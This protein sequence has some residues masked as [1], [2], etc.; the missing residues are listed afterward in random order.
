ML[1]YIAHIP[2]S[3]ALLPPISKNKAREFA[4]IRAAVNEIACDIYALGVDTIILL[5]PQSLASPGNFNINLA[6]EFLIDL[7]NYSYFKSHKPAVPD[8]E[9]A[10]AIA[11]DLGLLFPVK[12][13]NSD[14]LDTCAGVAMAQLANNKKQYQIIP[15]CPSAS[16]IA[17]LADFGGGL[18][19]VLE[20]HYQKTAV[21]GLG[22]MSRILRQDD[23]HHKARSFDS[24]IIN[25]LSSGQDYELN[26]E[27]A[28]KYQM[29]AYRPLNVIRGILRNVNYKTET[30][31]YQ[32]IYGVGMMV[33]RFL[34]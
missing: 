9:I 10:A 23:D 29:R 5:T 20:N 28:E 24:K 14:K 2:N 8:M 13:Y 31:I 27:A 11:N 4:K 7:S 16:P 1:T 6:E 19:E 3:P 25:L 21:I 26:E 17:S 18:R 22:D 32:Q 34:L 33:S 30:L 15:L 12:F